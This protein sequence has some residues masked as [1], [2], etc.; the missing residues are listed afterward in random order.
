VIDSLPARPL[1]ETEISALRAQ[2]GG[3][4]PLTFAG[5]DGDDEAWAV[6]IVITES[7]SETIHLLG[8][9]DDREGWALIEQWQG[10]DTDFDVIRD[11][12][13]VW[14]ESAYPDS[15]PVTPEDVS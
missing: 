6:T 12:A 10:G 4:M 13:A 1:S 3:V 2:H 15:D 5:S 9:D 14:L 8:F 11:R 7:E